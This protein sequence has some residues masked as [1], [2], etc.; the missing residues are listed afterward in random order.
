[1]SNPV[2]ELLTRRVGEVIDKDHLTKALNSTKRLR[3]KFGIDPTSSKMHLGHTVPLLKLKEFQNLGHWVILVIGDTTATIGDP[4]GRQVSRK[5]LTQE[6]VKE[7]MKAYERQISKVLDPKKTEFV[8]N[9]TWFKKMGISDLMKMASSATLQQVRKRREFQER[10]E[11]GEDISLTEILYPVMQGYDSV[12]VRAD[13]EIGGTDQK[14]NLL[15]GRQIQKRFGQ[16]EQDVITVPLLI[17]TDGKK[18]MSKT[19]GNY[20]ALD[21]TP[22]EMFAKI[23]SIPDELILNYFELCT[24]GPSNEIKTI[25]RQVVSDPMGTKKRLA[26]EI[27]QMYH[28]RE[29]SKRAQEEFVKVFSKEGI[30]D[31]APTWKLSGKTVNL[32]NLLVE[33]KIE[34]S[35]SEVRRL[36]KQG[37]ISLNGEKVMDIKIKFEKGILRIGKKTF[38]KIK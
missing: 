24:E 10:I 15:M 35:K 19:A 5:V 31:D 1:M 2:K 6:E 33:R 36:I 20:I 11:K 3:I 16:K 4:S 28:G 8:Y 38:I 25:K 27:T 26:L 34:D 21:D 22:N 13:V 14:F 7:N 18:K 32:P 29:K 30:P 17:G 9:S 37:G 23:M 12:Q